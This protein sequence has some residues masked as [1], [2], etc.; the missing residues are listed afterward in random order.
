MA[1]YLVTGISR[2]IGAE[3]AR[4]LLE[5]GED[6]IGTVRSIPAFKAE[7]DKGQGLLQLLEMDAGDPQSIKRAS[8]ALSTR[9]DILINNAGVLGPSGC[10]TDPMDHDEA[11]DTFRINVLGPLYVTRAFLPHLRR[12]KAAKVVTFTTR[13][14]SM[15]DMN[16]DQIVYRASKAAMNK[17]M[18]AMATDL[19]SEGITAV[20]MHPGW[21]KT[22]MGGPNALISPKDS[23][24]GVLARIDGYTMS[25]TGSFINYD[26]EQ[27]RF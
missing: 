1:T 25:D 19:R 23:V 16:S 14:G 21:V 7:A 27:L 13:M 10:T 11:L 6:V 9:I 20:A 15:T 3:L 18:Q 5:R 8:E 17:V 2:G 12:S 22:D 4:Q 26:G 24:S